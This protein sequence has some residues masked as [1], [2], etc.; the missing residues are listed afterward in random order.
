MADIIERES[1]PS[2]VD[3]AGH[4][5]LEAKDSAAVLEAKAIAESALH[6]ARVTKAANDTHADCLRIITRAEMRMANEIDRAQSNN[7]IAVAGSRNP[8]SSTY[9]ELGISRQRV[10]EWREVRDAGEAV[11]D[12]VISNALSEGR[13]PTRAEILKAAQEIRKEKLGQK[14]QKRAEKEER[15]AQKIAALPDARFG[16]ILADPPW[17]FEV[18]SELGMDRSADNHYP[19]QTTDDICQ[20]DIQS[21][22]ADN[23]ILFL[24]ATVPMLPDAMAVMASWDFT[25]KTHVVWV[26]D[27]IGTGYWFRNKH[28]ILLVGVKG[29]VPAPALGTQF[30]SVIDAPLGR[31][32]A[33]PEE[34]YRLI[35]TYY[36]TLPKLEMYARSPRDGWSV[37]GLESEGIEDE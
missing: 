28:E 37:C 7:E 21:V 20:L 18:R 10:Q 31:H 32:S 34:F 5:L 15:L 16:V 2:L 30:P 14:A 12:G 27:R 24:W 33:K 13:A 9:S 11:V 29:Y 25:Y 23:C 3:R 19:C 1:L 22:S 8:E 17:K 35:E 6:Y 26:K 36:P 4:R